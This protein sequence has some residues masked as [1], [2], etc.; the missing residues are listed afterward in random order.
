MK[1][2]FSGNISEYIK[3]KKEFCLS[4]KIF[5]MKGYFEGLLEEKDVKEFI[6]LLKEEFDREMTRRE[7]LDFIDKLA[8]SEL[9]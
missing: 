3:Q 9:Q 5:E 2:E 8:G 4:K 1:E 7:I 6:R